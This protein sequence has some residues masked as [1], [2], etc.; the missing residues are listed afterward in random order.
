MFDLDEFFVDPKQTTRWMRV[1]AYGE[2][3]KSAAAYLDRLFG[4]VQTRLSS[5]DC[6]D[7]NA[8]KLIA[9]GSRSLAQIVSDIGFSASCQ[10]HNAILDWLIA[11]ATETEPHLAELAVWGLGDIGIPPEIVRSELTRIAAG[12]SRQNEPKHATIR[13]VAF[14][15]LARVA[16]PDAELL[17]DSH[18]CKEY[19][20]SVENW[21]RE[22]E[23]NGRKGTESYRLHIEESAWLRNAKNNGLHTGSV[24]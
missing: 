22:L 11:L 23:E 24:G 16:R 8:I 7:I 5:V 14:R 10:Q 13:S 19:L 18:A 4:L 20:E 12:G 17:V 1:G 9:Y 15:M 21:L 2:L 6:E 3:G